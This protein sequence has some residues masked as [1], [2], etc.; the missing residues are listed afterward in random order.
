MRYNGF[1]EWLRNLLKADRK[2]L[3]D[4]VIDCGFLFF[5]VMV[6]I[7]SVAD[8]VY[9]YRRWNPPTISYKWNWRKLDSKEK[10]GD[11]SFREDDLID[12]GKAEGFAEKWDLLDYLHLVQKLNPE[13]IKKIPREGDGYSDYLWYNEQLGDFEY[14]VYNG[15]ILNLPDA[16]RDEKV[17]IIR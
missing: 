3:G 7:V 2:Q 4:Y 11:P 14:K 8:C 5:M 15:T 6:P 13:K 10:S 9:S 16:N 12:F 17:G 1:S